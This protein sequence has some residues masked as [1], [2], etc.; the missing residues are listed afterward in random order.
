MLK[1]LHVIH[2][3]SIGGIILIMNTLG[4]FNCENRKEGDKIIYVIREA[5]R[6]YKM[7]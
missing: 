6:E 1:N 4:K 5:Q 2:S 7:A 3:N